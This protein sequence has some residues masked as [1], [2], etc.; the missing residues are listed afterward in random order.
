MR[1]IA[2]MPVEPVPT[3]PTRWPLKSTPSCEPREA[4]AD[5]ERSAVAA[6]SVRAMQ[7][8]DLMSWND[9]SSRR[10]AEAMDLLARASDTARA[11][12]A[13]LLAGP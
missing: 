11:E 3:T 9:D 7:V 10:P 2:W 12:R 6:P 13:R 1:G 8:R 4:G 5:D